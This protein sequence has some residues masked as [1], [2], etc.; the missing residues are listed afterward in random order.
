MKIRIPSVSVR[1]T[2]QPL[3]AALVLAAGLVT[4]PSW[5]G[6]HGPRFAAGST[7]FCVTDPSRGFDDAAGVTD[8][9]RLILVEAWYPT[10]PHAAEQHP[11]ATFADTSTPAAGSWS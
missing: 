4:H 3:S 9:E 2:S 7:T 5:A 1:S 10:E 6:S 8:G 11:P